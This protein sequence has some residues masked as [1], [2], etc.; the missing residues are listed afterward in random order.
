MSQPKPLKPCPFC[1]GRDA[2]LVNCSV[3]IAEDEMA[4]WVECRGCGARTGDVSDSHADHLTASAHW[5][6]RA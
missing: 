3:R 1:G 5:N 4:A 6:R 2:D